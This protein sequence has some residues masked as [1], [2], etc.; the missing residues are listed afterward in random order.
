[1]GMLEDQLDEFVKVSGIREAIRVET[2]KRDEA[3]NKIVKLQE[4]CPHYSDHTTQKYRGNT[5]NYD[6]TADNYWVEIECLICG[7]KWREDQ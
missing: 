4:N 5:G 3:A 1:M 7:K 2:K 6:P